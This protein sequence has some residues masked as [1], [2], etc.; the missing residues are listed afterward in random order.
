M[1]FQINVVCVGDDGTEQQNELLVLS[2]DDLVMETMGLTLVESKALLSDLQGYLVDCQA[3]AYL[4]QHRACPRC[5]QRY[6]S[7]GQGTRPV[8][9]LFGPVAVPNPRWYRCP[10]TPTNGLRTFRPTGQSMAARP[11][12]P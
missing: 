3:A 4:E 10:C 1:K 11:K 9:T 8:N 12:Q 7:K 5:G 2:R 6:A